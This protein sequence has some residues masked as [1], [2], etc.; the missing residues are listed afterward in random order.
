MCRFP[1]RIGNIQPINIGHTMDGGCDLVEIDCN[2]WIKQYPQLKEWRIEVTNPDGLIYFAENV[3]LGEDGVLRWPI[4]QADTAV[5]GEGQYQVVAIGTDGQQKT[6]NHRQVTIHQTMPG[7]AQETPPDPAKPWTNEVLEAAKSAEASAKRAEDAC[8][9]G[10]IIGDNGNWYVYDWEKQEY[11]DTG[12]PAI[13]GGTLTGVVR[14]DR[15][16]E[17]TEEQKA[18]ARTNIGADGVHF[19]TDETLSL[20]PETG[21]LS[22]NT[23]DKVEADNTLPITAAAVQTSVGNINALL[24][25]I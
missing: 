11:M 15:K 20:D 16:M 6:S 8:T 25:T 19:T 14:Y 9:M 4:S 13:G 5:A 23:T 2:G 10:P 1:N 18:Q 17:L 7:T 21:V 3:A 22:V 24:A 12:V